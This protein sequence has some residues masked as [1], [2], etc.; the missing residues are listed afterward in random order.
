ML[1]WEADTSS[2]APT[3][4]EWVDPKMLQVQWLENGLLLHAITMASPPTQPNTHVLFVI[5]TVSTAVGIVAVGLA[6]WMVA[7]I[8]LLMWLI[9]AVLLMKS[10]WQVWHAPKEL[11]PAR[12]LL[13]ELSA[14]EIA[15]SLLASNR[16]GM[17]HDR[18]I[19]IALVE[20]VEPAETP[21]GLVVRMTILGG[22]SQDIPL[23]GLPLQDAQ[24]LADRIGEAV[25]ASGEAGTT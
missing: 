6:W 9:S 2:V 8:S 22:S 23:H 7:G 4:T 15:W 17:Q 18:K 25:A 19:G 13:V 14:T 24:W 5:A 1:R 12:R 20:R 3:P 16:F 21:E 11:P 10:A